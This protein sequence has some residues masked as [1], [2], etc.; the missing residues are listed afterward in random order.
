MSADNDSVDDFD[1]SDLDLEGGDDNYDEPATDD[2]PQP[3]AKKGP[4]ITTLAIYAAIGIAV[5]GVVVWQ[6]GLLGGAKAPVQQ[7]QTENAA[8]GQPATSDPFN[9]MGTPTE[10]QE[11]QLDSDNAAAGAQGGQNGQ[12]GAK[13]GM[14]ADMTDAMTPS[15]AGTPSSGAVP[16][17]DGQAP[18][19][20]SV[21]PAGETEGSAIPGVAGPNT[22]AAGS[23]TIPMPDTV[24]DSVMTTPAG[25]PP[26]AVTTTTTTTA[27]PVPTPAPG[28]EAAAPSAASLA[29]TP[30]PA[31]PA[32]PAVTTT[33]TS[34]STGETDTNAAALSAIM[35]RLDAIEKRL[36]AQPAANDNTSPAMASELQELKATVARLES[37]S[38][39]SARSDTA[40]APVK[41][42]SAP[43]KKKKTVKKKSS[44]SKSSSK[45][46]DAPYNGGATLNGNAA[47]ASSG[48]ATSS[49]YRLR[50]AQSDVAWVSDGSGS[51]RE[52]R[53]G[54]MLPGI[55]EVRSI[56]QNGS[57]WSVV[58][59]DGRIAP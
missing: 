11:M 33:T 16:M 47:S 9:V 21:M 8:P 37:G 26:A 10:Q 54:D 52:V 51:L 28:A 58:G 12:G 50:S 24:P 41:K 49:Q 27:A 31:E 6:M 30:V 1:F 18:S 20:T 7:A 36:D 29:V 40:S 43:V 14:P 46:A 17:P 38:S 39:S 22:P 32:A 57:S 5:I 2:E 23:E 35:D 15:G 42:A 4:D 53:V 44:S 56:Q 45:A 25:A 19:V 34:V 3:K 48:G 55:G 59:S 13:G